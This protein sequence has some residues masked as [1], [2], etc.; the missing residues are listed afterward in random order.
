MKLISDEDLRELLINPRLTRSGQYVCDCIFCGKEQHMYVSKRTQMF[1]CKKCHEYGSIYKI[2]QHLDKL[3][4]LAGSTVENKE[5]IDSIR[6]KNEECEDDIRL[7]ELPIKKM[8]AGWHILTNSNKYLLTRGITSQDCKRYN[9]GITNLF[10][11]YDKY[12][13]IPIY[14]GG[15][16]RGYIGRYGAKKVPDDKLRYNNSI[17]TEFAELLFGYDE[18]TNNTLTVVLV[19]G[20]FDKIAVDKA[21]CLFDDETVKCVCTF[22][23]KISPKQIHKLIIKGIINVI[24]LYDYDAIK[25]IKKYGVEL[26]KYFHTSITYTTKKDI[27]ECTRDEALK[28]FGKLKTPNEFIEDVIGK[29]KR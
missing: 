21:L 20:V 25:E 23:K 24:L 4:L 15:K 19:E 26:E 22:G 17:N 3:Y 27:D 7:A 9:I 5:H 6:R 11:R 1:D 28:V 12:I 10:S 8:P 29:L 18:I 13:L 16:I 2:L 14:D